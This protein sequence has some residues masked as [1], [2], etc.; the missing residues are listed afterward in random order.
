MIEKLRSKEKAKIVRGHDFG[1]STSESSEKT[2]PF[3]CGTGKS[4]GV[5]I[6]VIIWGTP[7]GVFSSQLLPLSPCG[8]LCQ[9]VCA[10]KLGPWWQRY[11]K[12][13]RNQKCLGGEHQSDHTHSVWKCGPSASKPTQSE[14]GSTDRSMVIFKHKYKHKIKNHQA[15]EKN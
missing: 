3:G 11:S 15:F 8:K 10:Y 14:P 4:P 1:D 5:G 6:R 9:G 2:L 12:A 13:L 7:S